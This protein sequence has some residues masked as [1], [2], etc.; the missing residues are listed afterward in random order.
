MGGG[1]GKRSWRNK[2]VAEKVVE[3]LT[4]LVQRP[5]DIPNTAAGG[6]IVPE[7]EEEGSRHVLGLRTSTRLC[8]LAV[9]RTNRSIPLRSSHL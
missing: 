5:L 9:S 1:E 7:P 6:T 2:I 3:I 8:G 4:G